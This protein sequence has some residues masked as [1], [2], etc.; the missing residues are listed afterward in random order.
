[1]K[2]SIKLVV[3]HEGK[4]QPHKAELVAVANVRCSMKSKLTLSHLVCFTYLTKF[5]CLREKTKRY[6]LEG[7][8][9][10]VGNTKI[11][12]HTLITNI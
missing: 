10:H 11:Q 9:V 6:M 8:E 4:L 7:V 3:V 5:N 1:M 12:T 2:T